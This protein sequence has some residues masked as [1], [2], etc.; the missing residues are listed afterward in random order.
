MVIA[1]VVEMGVEVVVVVMVVVEVVVAVEGVVV[2]AVVVALVVIVVV[3]VVGL[4][5][6]SKNQDMPQ[7][8][9]QG[10]SALYSSANK[11]KRCSGSGKGGGSDGGSGDVDAS[12]GVGGRCRW[13]IFGVPNPVQWKGVIKRGP[14]GFE[15]GGW[16]HDTSNIPH[17]IF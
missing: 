4:G 9:L 13:C 1:V 12:G 6:T 8:Q 14:V 10:P 17:N 7:I 2:A 15:A 16:C 3:V 5:W 11:G